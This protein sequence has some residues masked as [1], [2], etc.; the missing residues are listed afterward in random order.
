MVTV[1]D[2]PFLRFLQAQHPLNNLY[3]TLDY[4]D[5][6]LVRWLMPS[7]QDKYGLGLPRVRVPRASVVEMFKPGQF[8]NLPEELPE[9]GEAQMAAHEILWGELIREC[10]C[11]DSLIQIRFFRRAGYAILIYELDVIYAKHA[12]VEICTNLIDGRELVS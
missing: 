10:V 8:F 11:A 7:T 4:F 12:E 3:G 2:I 6:T 1:L 9:K 5:V